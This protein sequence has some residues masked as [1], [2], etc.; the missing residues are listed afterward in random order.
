MRL[1]YNTKKQVL[2]PE[3]V[4]KFVELYVKINEKILQSKD[5]GNRETASTVQNLVQKP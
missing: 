4:R 2:T 3:F 1:S 5:T